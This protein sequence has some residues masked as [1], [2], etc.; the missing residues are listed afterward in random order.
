MSVGAALL[1]AA[2]LG[3]LTL[4]VLGL[5]VSA[6][7]AAWME[8][9]RDPRFA[10]ALALSA[11]TSLWS[12]AIIAL[13]GTPLAWWLARSRR[14]AARVVGVLVDLPIV[15]PPAVIGVAL[16]QT[17]GRQG[18]L[19]PGLDALGVSL[20]FTGWAV[21]LAQVTVAAPFYVQ[22]AVNAFRDVD[23]ELL[24]VARTLGATRVET[25]VRVV[26]PVALPGLIAGL[27]LAWARALGE[28]GA[29]L[30]F[31]GNMRGVTQTM[32]LA[33]FTA[34]EDDVRVAIALSLLLIALGALILVA[35][36]LSSPLLSRLIFGASAGQPPEEEAR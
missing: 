35:L 32:P 14:G 2:L 25:F 34:L 21:I 27:S 15:I 13:T 36:R 7:P 5:M 22:A 16:L 30:L 26:L 23:S 4:P 8:G 6:S 1:G 18:W 9:A 31:A 24:V 11:R 19:G 10:S 28:F 12:V 33:I 29:T 20:P 3:L 17:F